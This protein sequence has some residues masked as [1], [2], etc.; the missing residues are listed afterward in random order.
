MNPVTLPTAWVVDDDPTMRDILA[1]ALGDHF[2]IQQA[3]SGEETL[4][5][6]VR[7]PAP[8][9]ATPSLV[10]LDIEM[11]MLDG[12]QT[13]QRLRKAGLDIPVLFVSS[14]DT[15]E[16]RLLAFDAG[17]DDFIS[18]PFDPDV[19]LAKAQRAY[20][21]LEETRRIEAEKS[22]LQE[23]TMRI[24]HEVGETGVLLD[25]LRDALRVADY[26]SLARKLLGTVSDYG[27]QCHVQIRHGEGALTLTPEGMPTALEESILNHAATLGTQFRLGKRLILNSEQVSLLV[28]DMPRD[29]SEA[30]RL[31]GYLEV[32]VESAQA[33]AET[34]D[35]RQES[36][37]RAEALMVGS[38]ESYCT[39]TDLRLGYS[40]Q[41][42][43]TRL[44]LHEMIDE[45]EKS[46]VHL[47]L[48]DRQEAAVSETIRHSADKILK[49]FELGVNIDRQ[50]AAVL[51]SMKP[52]TSSAP[53]VW[54]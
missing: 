33:M 34:I 4:E 30:L 42:I 41:Q 3:A 52:K 31:T 17:G 8:G 40:Q 53:E 32:L 38:L 28:I 5:H 29:E 12:Y 22:L 25:F 23:T 39:L 9:Q 11:D 49:L 24:L 1:I 51:D 6:L 35:M 37:A 20:A 44:L 27:I 26:E 46:Y 36:A 54:I 15:L 45:V 18:K 21:R 50:F 43:D 48:T 10:L 47:G 16:E 19:V 13:C 14:H 2:D 7:R